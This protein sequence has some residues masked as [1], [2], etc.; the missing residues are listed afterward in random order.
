MSEKSLKRIS[1]FIIS[2]MVAGLAI[3]SA[4]KDSEIP[5]PLSI[6][7]KVE[8][9]MDTLFWCALTAYHEARGEG[10][11]AQ[12]AVCH[13]VLNRMAKSG[14]L[15]SE[16]VFKPFQFTW[17]NNGNRPPIKE[18]DSFLHCLKSAR[19]VLNERGDGYTMD[20][21]NIFHDTSTV[22]EKWDFNKLTFIKQIGKLKFYRES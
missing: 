5:A 16:V 11:E 14:K 21:I 6:N 9:D 18:Y 1:I 2:S 3:L 12:M 17:A 8:N 7:I 10:Q 15:A 19:I 20:G 4:F 22:P 13:V